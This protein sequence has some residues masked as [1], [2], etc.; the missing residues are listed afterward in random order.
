[1]DEDLKVKTR[2]ALFKQDI[3]AVVAVGVDNVTYL[4]GCVLPFADSYPDRSA[5]LI[6]TKADKS[7]II[8]PFDWAE[9]IRDQEWEG[10]LEIYNENAGLPPEAAVKTLVT[11]LTRLRLTSGKLSLDVSRVPQR[12]MEILNTSLPS[13]DWVSMDTPLRELRMIKTEGEIKL[14]ETA[15][16]QSDKGL[17]GALQHLE[18]AVESPGYT[19]SEFS[20]RVRVHTIEYGG[21]GIG[22]L[23]TLQG[24]DAIQPY[25]LEHGIFRANNLVRMEVTNHHLGYWSNASRMAVIGS[26]STEQTKAYQDN[27]SL[28]SAA[29]Q[30]LRPG[31]PCAQVFE[32]VLN[33]ATKANLRF[34]QDAGVGHSVGIGHREAPY[35]HAGDLTPLQPGMVISLDIQSY[36]P[37]GE[38]IRSKDTFEI[39]EDGSRLLSWHKDWDRLYEVTGFR[40]AH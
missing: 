19:L 32:E 16:L 2:Q 1:M 14:L 29:I 11:A 39:V 4:S 15:A 27:L 10:D 3:E 34:R 13:V 6:Q 8:C 30:A 12:I 31:I 7:L 23:A 38:L 20:E 40:A 9:A 36:G 17:L 22:H 26:P 5:V 33:S 18:G 37:R 28:K 35:L 24:K 25:V 21:S